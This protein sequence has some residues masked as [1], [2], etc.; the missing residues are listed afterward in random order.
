MSDR[1]T[2]LS[3][4]VRLIDRASKPLT[5]I[6]RGIHRLTAGPR[7]VHQALRAL[8]AET[9]PPRLGR[10]AQ[11]VGRTIGKVGNE[12]GRLVTKLAAFGGVGG[13]LFKRGFLDTA[14]D[15]E[16][17]L[18]VLETSEGSAGK[19]RRAF[20]WVN[21]FA[22]QTPFQLGEV[23]G[24][25]VNLR[26]LGLDPTSG[27]LKTLGDTAAALTVPLDQAV[28]AMADAVTGEN[29]RLKAFGITAQTK[30]NKVH[31]VYSVDG[32]EKFKIVERGNRAM[33]QSTLEAI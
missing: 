20:D 6:N 17:F 21:K 29:E 33:I 12:T 30:G 13:F 25:F 9:A 1:E 19:A 4:V 27:L 16:K 31:F 2:T 8:G 32:K 22:V 3:M 23:T 5:R 18:A 24:A 28:Q 7:A 14:A 26:N 11:N 10:E 15:F